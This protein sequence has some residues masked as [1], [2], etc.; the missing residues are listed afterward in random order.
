MNAKELREQRGRLITQAREI[1]DA[2][3]ADDRAMTDEEGVR[4]D[5]FHAE[6][7]QLKDRYEQIERQ[8]D[9]EAEIAASRTAAATGPLGGDT[10][11][12]ARRVVN[13]EQ[14]EGRYRDA[15]RNWGLMGASGMDQE[16]RTVLTEQRVGMPDE[17][18]ADPSMASYEAAGGVS[19]SLLPT[20]RMPPIVQTGSRPGRFDWEARAP[21]TVTTTGGGHVIG[22]EP[23]RGIEDAL[24]AFGGMRQAADVIRTAT[25][26]DMPWPTADDTGQTGELLA[27]NTAAA[28]Q[29]ITFGQVVL[30][31][32][33]YSSKLVLVPFELMQDSSFD[34]GAYVGKKL[35][36][37]IGRITNTHFTTGSGSGEPNGMK[38][39]GNAAV[40]TV[41]S[42]S[43]VTGDELI[44]LQGD[45]DPAYD[46]NAA[47]MMKRATLTT[48]RK[49][50]TTDLQY[51]WI[52]GLVGRE[53]DTLLGRPIIIN[54]DVRGMNADMRSI[55]YGD[56]KAYK[57]RDVMGITLL[58]LVER[59][60]ELA[61]IGFVAF[62]RHDGDIIDAGTNPI[63]WIRHP[64]S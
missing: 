46:G 24:L 10:N 30:Q 31:A 20:H 18:R 2:A 22:D 33:K 45:L 50:K 25:G 44:E 54:Q 32:F 48:L 59:Y 62:S 42:A 13:V 58:R 56:F 63:H 11:D 35:G 40:K 8:E 49:L 38:N 5:A 3:D 61:Q 47:W 1:L 39:V 23:I 36:E 52:P 7:D 53:P 55:A 51:I 57:I 26:A 34:F 27:I 43:A 9:R 12:P 21:Q 16:L 14:A 64:A 4:F 29:L 6:A 60:A 41:A 37:R 28:E 15:L 19:L 17:L